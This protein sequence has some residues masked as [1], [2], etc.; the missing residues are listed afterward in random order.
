MKNIGVDLVE[1]EEIKKVGIDKIANRILSNEEN[2]IYQKI[3]HL[4]RKISFL[5]GRWAAKEA[6]FK[7]YRKGDYQ[8]NYSDW[9]I[10]NDEASGFPY[11]IN[12]YLTCKIM[13]SISHS[14]NY[15]LAFVVLL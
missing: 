4:T 10:L 3:N 8:N 7:A 9:S 15:A 13:I 1:L 14:K 5:A 6:I 2:L 12:S 11:V